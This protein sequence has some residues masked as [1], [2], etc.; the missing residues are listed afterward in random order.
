MK[1]DEIYIKTNNEQKRYRNKVLIEMTFIF[2]NSSNFVL[3]ATLKFDISHHQKSSEWFPDM[4]ERESFVVVCL[5]LTML[6]T[7]FSRITTVTGY[8]TEL[9]A[10]FYNA[11]SL[12]Y[13][14][15]D[16]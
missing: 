13:H 8:D 2:P 3:M 15:Q 9:N 11:A 10:H 14:A 6:S 16:T 7:I 12:K 1:Q 5:G 4:K